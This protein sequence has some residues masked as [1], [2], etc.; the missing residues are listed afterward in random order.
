MKVVQ[1]GGQPIGGERLA[2]IAGPC[3]LEAPSIA[4]EVAAR[5]REICGVLGVPFVFKAS[6][7]KANRTSVTSYRGP[8][9][10]QGLETLAAIK[11]SVGVPVLSDIHEVGQ[12]RPAAEVLDM[13]QVPAFL[14][15]QTDLL[16]AVGDTGLPVNIKKGQFLAPDDMRHCIEKVRS[17]GNE[18]ITLCERGSTFGYHNLVVDMRGLV[19]MRGFGYPVVFDA[20]HSVQLPGGG[21]GKSA[22]ERQFVAPLAR[23][24]VAAGV[25]AVFAEVHPNPDAALCDGPNMLPLDEVAPLLRTLLEVRSACRT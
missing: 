7:D 16:V 13:L 17:T 23:A 5:L 10:E 11:A 12:V 25:D 4:R 3:V 18:S 20:T 2:L 9:L 24:A 6:F 14:S 19:I 22:G 1:V 21:G 8:G 15:R